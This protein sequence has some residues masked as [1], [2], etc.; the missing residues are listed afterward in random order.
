LDDGI[1]RDLYYRAFF[2]RGSGSSNFVRVDRVFLSDAGG[3]A[4]M[5]DDGGVDRYP[6]GR[7]ATQPACCAFSWERRAG[8]VYV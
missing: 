7:V 8:D 3:C 6:A 4:P 2:P 5:G 1:A